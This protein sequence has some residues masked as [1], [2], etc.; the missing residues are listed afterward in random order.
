M[1]AVLG[2]REMETKK[3]YEQA[4]R[5][6]RFVLAVAAP[7]PEHKEQ[8]TRILREH[9]AHT[10]AFF[11]KHTSTSYRPTKCDPV[12]LADAPPANASAGGERQTLLAC[13]LVRDPDVLLLDEPTNRHVVASASVVIGALGARLDS[14]P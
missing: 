6:N 7:T 8:A 1:L 12:A 13:A 11:G 10:V 2:T 5:E 4:M 14:H 9:G 3:R